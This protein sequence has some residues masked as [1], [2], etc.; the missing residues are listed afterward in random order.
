MITKIFTGIGIIGLVVL[1]IIPVILSI[2]FLFIGA[3]ILKIVFGWLGNKTYYKNTLDIIAFSSLPEL[4]FYLL[5]LI[6]YINKYSDYFIWIF[7]IWSLVLFIFGIKYHYQIDFGKTLAGFFVFLIIFGFIS[8]VII[9]IILLFSLILGLGSLA[10]FFQGQIYDS[11]ESAKDLEFLTDILKENVRENIS[12]NSDV[13]NNLI[14]QQKNVSENQIQEDNRCE[15]ILDEVSLRMHNSYYEFIEGHRSNSVIP[16]DDTNIQ[17]I[18]RA[19]YTN[20]QIAIDNNG[21]AC[22]CFNEYVRFEGTNEEAILAYGRR[23]G[24]VD[25][26][27]R[28]KWL[29]IEGGENLTLSNESA[30]I[31]LKNNGEGIG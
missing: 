22:Q 10:L 28:I 8:T 14:Q 23:I 6:P 27:N 7:V 18:Y 12:I 9:G 1:Y 5:M 26:G 4:I 31:T 30:I 2:P 29:I 15:T 25:K 16:V 20:N 11:N 13:E 3:L 17:G 21:K 24:Q 19:L